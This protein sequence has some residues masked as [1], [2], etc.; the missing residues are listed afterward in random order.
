MGNARISS[1]LPRL[2]PRSARSSTRGCRRLLPRQDD[3]EQ[4]DLYFDDLSTGR[5]SA[6]EKG[7]W[8]GKARLT[9]EH[10]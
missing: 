10:L 9:R 8:G 1:A 2:V 7:E 3:C 5:S 4:Q 6:E